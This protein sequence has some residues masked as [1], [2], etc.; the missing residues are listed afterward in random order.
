MGG[1]WAHRGVVGQGITSSWSQRHTA[2]PSH[3]CHARGRA[4]AGH[5]WGEPALLDCLLAQVPLL[6]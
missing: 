1:G 5:D 6:Y 4:C 2:R 3:D